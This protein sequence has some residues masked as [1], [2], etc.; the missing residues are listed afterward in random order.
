MKMFAKCWN[1]GANINYKT[2][3]LSSGEYYTQAKARYEGHLI[4]FPNSLFDIVKVYSIV[5]PQC[6]KNVTCGTSVLEVDVSIER[7]K[8]RG[9]LIEKHHSY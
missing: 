4:V 9:N 6:S 5:C 1:C 3:D 7:V 2:D 8:E